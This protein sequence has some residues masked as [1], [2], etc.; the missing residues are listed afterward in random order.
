MYQLFTEALKDVIVYFAD[1][2]ASWQKGLVEYTNK[3]IRQYIPKGVDFDDFSSQKSMEIQKILNARHRKNL[4]SLQQRYSR[5]NIFRNFAPRFTTCGQI[6][7]LATT[8]KNA[9]IA[10]YVALLGIRP[11]LEF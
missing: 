7:L 10:G 9:K 1:P 8:Q 6:W 2:Y 4:I 5:S 3:L 11:T